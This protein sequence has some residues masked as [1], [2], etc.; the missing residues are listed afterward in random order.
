MHRWVERIYERSPVVLQHAMVSAYGWR[1]KQLRYGGRHQKYLDELMRSQQY[2]EAEL[3][4]LQAEN[5]RKLIQHCYENV[6]Y[7]GQ[8]LRQLKLTPGDFRSASDLARLPV[9]DKETVRQQPELFYARNYRNAPC[10]V[11]STSGTTGTTLRIRVDVEGRR[12]NY[13]FFSRLKLWAGVSPFSRSATWGGRV[14]VPAK[15][16]RPPF[17]RYNWAFNNLLFSSYHLSESNL[18]A[19]VAKLRSWKP[20]VIESYPSSIFVLARYIEEHQVE[21]PSPR[22]IIT[23]AETL[24]PHQREV[25]QSGLGTKIFDQYGA[26]EQICFVSQCEQGSYH[27]HPEFGVLE[28]L[29]RAHAA[30]SDSRIVATGF[31]NWAMPLLRYDTGDLAIAASRACACQRNFPMLEQILGR[32]DDFILT[33]D[34]RYVGRLDPVFKG[35]ESIRKAQIVQETVDRLRIRV[36]PGEGFSPRDMDSV[37]HELQKRLGTEVECNFEVVDDI[38]LGPGG[39]FRAVISRVRSQSPRSE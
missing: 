32:Q 34:G 12:K 23:S 7:Y 13:A 15:A 35:L 26:A 39:K 5:V 14:I 28:S 21:L 37:R 36:V 10:E 17:W 8:L 9:L 31:T 11:V 22:A 16:R 6:P 29:P 25:V 3:Q 24:L 20:E 38:P 2:S 30:G 1:L 27:V 18:P 19:Y 4:E 33:R